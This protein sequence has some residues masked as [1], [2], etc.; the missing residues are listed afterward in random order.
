MNNFTKL[1]K[2]CVEFVQRY[3]DEVKFIVTSPAEF[4]RKNR[5]ESGFLEPTIFAGI[6]ILIPQLLYG[7]LFAPITLGVSMFF[8]IPT[9]IYGTASF[10]V[11]AIVLHGL[12]Q[13]CDGEGSFEIT[14]RGVAYSSVAC[15]AWLAP[16][17]FVNVL[18]F[19]AA[20]CALLYISLREAHAMTSQRS[21]M[22]LIGPAFL[23]LVSGFV[24]TLITLWLV[25]HGIFWLYSFL[26]PVIPFN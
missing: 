3:I 21:M 25:L 9:V 18:L 23:L 2:R 20:F 1:Q 12:I 19:T 15:Y 17:P 8:I 22:V 6:S 4:F 14:Y 26:L 16:I 11:A 7:L 5:E 24:L 10:M 13:I